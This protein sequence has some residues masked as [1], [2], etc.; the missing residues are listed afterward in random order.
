MTKVGFTVKPDP[1]IIRCDQNAI[2]S[3]PSSVQNIPLI[4]A[5]L[6]TSWVDCRARLDLDLL[7][8]TYHT[9]VYLNKHENPSS[10]LYI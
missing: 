1:M 9:K 6:Q 10:E 4:T 8:C 3:V 5:L 2:C 7:H